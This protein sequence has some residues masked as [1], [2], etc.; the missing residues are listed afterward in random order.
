MP[1]LSARSPTSIRCVGRYVISFACQVHRT[2]I[3]SACATEAGAALQI[4]G[5]VGWPCES[6]MRG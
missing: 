2:V 6:V 3:E 1:P 5:A 4:T